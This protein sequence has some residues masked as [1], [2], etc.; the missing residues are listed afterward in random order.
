VDWDAYGVGLELGDNQQ[1]CVAAFVGG[2]TPDRPPATRVCVT[3][4][5]ARKWGEIASQDRPPM[6]SRG[7]LLV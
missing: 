5:E 6:P 3:P 7:K 4:D 2:A 1:R